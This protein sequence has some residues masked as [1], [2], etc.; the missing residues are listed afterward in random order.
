[1]NR[2]A[3]EVINEIIITFQ[4]SGDRA[5]VDAMRRCLGHGCHEL[6]AVVIVESKERSIW[7]E[8]GAGGG[9]SDD[10]MEGDT[11][12]VGGSG[13]TGHD[14]TKDSNHT[15]SIELLEVLETIVIEDNSLCIF[16]GREEVAFTCVVTFIKNTTFPN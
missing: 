11:N 6:L 13:I 15:T 2:V 8:V 12:D 9:C 16:C 10:V 1:M 5:E 4:M 3:Q 7:V 14:T